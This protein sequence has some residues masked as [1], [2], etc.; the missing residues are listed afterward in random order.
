MVRLDQSRIKAALVHLEKSK[1]FTIGDLTSTLKCS[2]PNARVKLKQWRTYTS[3]NQNG[4]YYTLPQVPQFDHH[5]LWNYDNAAFSR[6]GN[7]KKTIVHLV[8]SAPAGLTGKQLGNLLGLSPQSFMHHFRKCPGICREK[9][10][11]VYVYFSDITSIYESQVEERLSIIYRSAVVTI[12]DSEAVMILVA[13]IRHHAISAEEILLLPEIRKNKI[14]LTAIQGFLNF[15]G[16]EKKT[17]DS[18]P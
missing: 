14:K 8:T 5:G 6:H 4:R 9:H 13:I 10:V 17:S 3:Y 1:T 16:L 11:G 12:S 2:T 7:L 18:S 15:H